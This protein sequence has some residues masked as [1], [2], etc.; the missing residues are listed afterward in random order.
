[1][2][3]EFPKLFFCFDVLLEEFGDDLV[4]VGQL[5][6][7]QFDAAFPG[8]LDAAVLRG[9]LEGLVGLG[10]HGVDPGVNLAGLQAELLGQGG[11]GLLAG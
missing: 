10:Q 7:E 6:F 11:N 3:A 2:R 5:G 9:P 1:M 4:L 8:L